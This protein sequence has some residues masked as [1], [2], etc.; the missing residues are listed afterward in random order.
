MGIGERIK[1]ERNRLN[2]KQKDLAEFLGVAKSTL[3]MWETD[4]REPG[5]DVLIKLSKKFNVTIDYLLGIS[6]ERISA[7]PNFKTTLSEQT[8]IQ[9]YR[10]LD[11]YGNDM[12]DTV[13][14]KEFTRMESQSVPQYI[15]SKVAARGGGV[16]THIMTKE[17]LEKADA[18]TTEFEGFDELQKFDLDG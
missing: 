10:K 2:I 15:E 18:E 12:V 8:H 7:N 9:K 6:N 1:S 3:G 14:D 16:M 4:K 11:A 17:E 13:L 5:S